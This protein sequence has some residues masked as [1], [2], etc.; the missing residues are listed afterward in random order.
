MFELSKKSVENKI[1]RTLIDALVENDSVTIEGV[2]RLFWQERVHS[3]RFEPNPGFVTS[4]RTL[5]NISV[6]EGGGKWRT[7]AIALRMSLGLETLSLVVMMAT[8]MKGA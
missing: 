5:R 8:K 7:G 6:R 2:G 1:K 3:V 4:I